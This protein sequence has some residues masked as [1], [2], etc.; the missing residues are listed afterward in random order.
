MGITA[1]IH[2]IQP[3]NI[4]TFKPGNVGPIGEVNVRTRFRQ[5]RAEMPWA[6]DPYW[7]GPRA[8]KLGS[9]VQDGYS[10]SYGS[11]GGPAS[12]TLKGWNGNRSFKHQYGYSIHDVQ[13][14]DLLYLPI[15][16]ELK[17]FSYKQK[18]GRLRNVK[19]GSLFLPMGYTATGKPRGGLYP[20]STGFGGTT[21]AS[22]A[23]DPLT[24]PTVE[25]DPNGP[26]PTN[27][28]RAGV[29]NLGRSQRVGDVEA[30]QQLRNLNI[31]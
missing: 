25:L 13:A 16:S 12:T 29:S 20:T 30:S 14:S 15:D 27:V 6:I 26:K 4:T 1:L 2:D 17:R 9:N 28:L 22:Q 18:V 23:F 7:T 11:Q 21:P 8:H 10:F 5:S 31:K 19:A 3:K 24:A